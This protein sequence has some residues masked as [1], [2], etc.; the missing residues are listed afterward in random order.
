M[1]NTLYHISFTIYADEDIFNKSKT[2]KYFA[3][4][5]EIAKFTFNESGVAT[6]KVINTKANLKVNGSTLANIP[7]GNYYAKE[8]KVPTGYLKDNEKHTLTLSYKDSKAKTISVKGNVTNQ[9]QKAKFEII[10]VSGKDSN[11]AKVVENDTPFESC[12]KIIKVDQ[13][14]GKKITFSNATFKLYKLNRDT[15]EWE[16]TSCKIGKERTFTWITDENAVAY[17]EDKLEAG[18]YKIDEIKGPTGFVK[19]EQDCNIIVA[20][21]S[22]VGKTI[23]NTD[24]A[25]A[26][27]NKLMNNEIELESGEKDDN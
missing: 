8:T 24:N 9:V 11:T 6:I 22:A 3:K 1:L 26:E 18:T 21:K 25:Q 7:L 16:E 14:T 27:I 15:N 2:T 19:L 12:L 5:K 4:D 20:M 17:T 23:G 13:K 10:K